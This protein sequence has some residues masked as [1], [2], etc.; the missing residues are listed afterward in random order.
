MI[1]QPGH[2]SPEPTIAR[3]DASIHEY[4]QSP[5]N[6]KRSNLLQQLLQE[7]WILVVG[8]TIRNKY[9]AAVCQLFAY[10]L[11]L[12]RCLTSF[13]NVWRSC[14]RIPLQGFDS[15]YALAKNL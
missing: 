13:R 3:S 14:S 4:P 6:F 10:G 9:P 7:I 2:D 8:T 15:L 11:R 12:S 5:C 1:C